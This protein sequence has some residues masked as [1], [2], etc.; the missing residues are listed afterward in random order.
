VESLT[1]TSPTPLCVC[2]ADECVWLLGYHAFTPESVRLP[3]HRHGDRPHRVRLY[4]VLVMGWTELDIYVRCF[5][6]HCS[7]LRR[8]MYIYPE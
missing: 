1:L 2:L 7:T 8:Y 3:R 5:M 4:N 6:L